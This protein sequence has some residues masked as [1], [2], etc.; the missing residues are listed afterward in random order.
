MILSAKSTTALW[1]TYS[2]FKFSS[3]WTRG[4]EAEFALAEPAT[5][6]SNLGTTVCLGVEPLLPPKKVLS[7]QRASSIKD[8]DD[9]SSQA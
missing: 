6:G 1:V 4:T 2:R 3:M 8:L 5:P 9:F 7:K